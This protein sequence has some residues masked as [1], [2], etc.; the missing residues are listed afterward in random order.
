MGC[1]IIENRPGSFKAPPA[2]SPVLP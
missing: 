2:A 1:H